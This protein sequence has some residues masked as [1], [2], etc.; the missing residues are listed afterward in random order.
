MPRAG[1]SRNHPIRVR[2]AWETFPSVA[3]WLR[4]STLPGLWVRWRAGATVPPSSRSSSSSRVC[5]AM[6]GR[7]RCRSRSASRCSTTTA[8]CGAR[9]RCRSSSTSSCAASSRWPRRDPTLRERQ[10][11]KAAY[12]HDYG[13]LGKV[14]A[15]HYAGDDTN[16]EVLAGGVL[17][18]HAG[19]QRRGLRGAGGRVPAQRAAPDARPR[20]PRVRLRA[21]GRAARLPGGQRL[22]E[23]HRLR[24]RPRLHAADQ[25]GG[26]R[27]PARAGDRQQHRRSPTPATSTAA[28][29]P[30][31]RRPTTST[32][33]RR[34]RSA[35]GAAPADGRCSRRATPTATSRCSHF[36][37]HPDKP[38]L[39][40]LVLHDDAEREFA[41]TTGAEQALEQA[42]RDGWTVVSVKNDWAT[43]F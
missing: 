17:A 36:T 2:P 25:P 18:A 22:H 32:T 34:S 33:A 38:S 28:R 12:E 30:A 35:S 24:R 9:S 23:L 8:R 11:W 27:H 16:V 19:H 42:A 3:A 15:E 20:L 4:A 31:R 29:S 14:M 5:A 40:L 41:Y 39:R 43:V 1:Q 37:Q 7:S 13:W 10:P 26:V 6:A 21:D